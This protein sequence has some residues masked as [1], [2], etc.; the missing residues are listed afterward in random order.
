M[1]SIVAASV[2][3]AAVLACSSSD[4][5]PASTG[6]GRSAIIKGAASDASQDAAILLAYYDAASGQAGACSGTMLSPRIVLTARHCVS[7]T[8]ESSACNADGKALAGGKVYADHKATSLFVFT[9]TSRPDF[10]TGRV[11]PQGNGLKLVTD[12]AKTMCNHDVAL[13]VLAEPVAG[14]VIAPV[15][16][17]GPPEVGEKI[18]AVGWGVTDKTQEPTTRQQRADVPVL[19]VGPDTTNMIANGEFIVGESI[20]SGDSGGPAF[21]A[22]GAVVGVVS[23]GGNG[24]AGG[25]PSDACVGAQTRNIYS[26]PAAFKDL[27]ES[28]FAETGEEP[29]IEGQP[30]PR[31]K[32]GK[33]ACGEA[34][35]CRSNACLAVSGGNQCAPVDCTTDACPDGF[36]CG[37]VNGAKACV[38][39]PPTTTTTTGCQTGG[40]SSSG[41]LFGLVLAAAVVLLRRKKST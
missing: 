21:A 3:C 34:G 2:L 37:D 20:C 10:S 4:P 41:S 23:R 39:V 18:T 22:S 25:N 6:T 16:F 15:R 19:V 29:W 24:K 1:R 13:V 31:L 9:G 14:A 8:D 12:G 40:G 30:D 38:A 35:E 36:Q 26:H 28:A 17:S 33:E 11:T 7:Q 5:T 32:K 27:I